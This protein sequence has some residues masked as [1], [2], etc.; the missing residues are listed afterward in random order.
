MTAFRQLPFTVLTGFLG[1]G[2]TTLLNRMLATTTRKLA[3]LV[4]DLG[5]INVDKRLLSSQSGDLLELSGG[6]ICCQIDLDR[7][8]WTACAE[9]VER[10]HPDQLVLETTGIADPSVILRACQEDAWPHRALGAIGVVTV[11]DATAGVKT[12]AA[13]AE[14][15]GQVIHAD[16]VIVSKTDRATPDE[17]SALHHALDGLHPGVER[18]AFP[19][20]LDGDRALLDYALHTVTRRERRQHLSAHHHGQI[21]VVTFVDDGVFVAELLLDE[22]RRLAPSLLRAKGFVRLAGGHGG[23]LELASGEATLRDS[24][25]VARTE[26]VFIGEGLDE[27]AIRGRL[28]ACRT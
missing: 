11:V 15:R 9:L 10:A 3:V 22:L 17:L 16:R 7:D 13:R 14:A 18:A 5:Q 8:L 12:L 27:P 20:Q 21:S 23:F 4:N 24:A 28:W 26:L 19:S 25:P 6:C 2:K 1:A